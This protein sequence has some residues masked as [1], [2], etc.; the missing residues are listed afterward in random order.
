MRQSHPGWRLLAADHAPLVASFLHA[1]FIAPNL[2][3]LARQD[4]VVRLD[5]LLHHLRTEHDEGRFPRT[6]ADYLDDWA[7][8][9]KGWLRKYY[10]PG[11]DEPHYDLTPAAEKALEW[12]DSLKQRQFVGT[13]SRLRTVFDLLRGIVEGSRTDPAERIADLER[14]RADID[15]EIARVRRGDVPVMDATQVK[16]SFQQV[17]ATARSLLG[18]FR[19]VE[20][21]FRDLD[22]AIRERITTWDGAKADLLDDILGRRDHIADSDQ[23]KSFRAFWDFLMSPDRQ[24]ELGTLLRAVLALEAVQQMQ[25]DRRLVRIHHDWLAA[26]EATQATVRRLSEQLRRYLDDQAWYEDRRILHIIRDIEGHALALRGASA[27][28][29]ALGMDMEGD[30]PDL[31]LPFERP[32]YTPPFRPNIDDRIEDAEDVDIPSDALHSVFHI[33]R[34]ALWSHIQEALAGQPQVSLPDLL[35]EYPLQDGLAELVTYVGLASEDPAAVID[36]ETPTMLTW[37]SDDGRVRRATLPQI[38]FTRQAPD[39][40]P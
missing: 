1:S 37:T 30:A 15:A 31:A 40:T 5:D 10:P 7:D 22:R 33:D 8:D 4:L 13:E 29:P 38:I 11:Q 9:A 26:G 18:D 12:L 35:N 28:D 19:E 16:D 24:E 14:R 23:G 34:A 20:Q 21:N 39:E 32:L 6:A 27:N 25:P 3:T 36:D 2:R 17:A